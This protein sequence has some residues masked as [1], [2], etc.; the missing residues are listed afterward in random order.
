MKK[1][2]EFFFFFKKRGLT[3]RKASN[4]GVKK[5]TFFPALR[6]STVN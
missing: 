2:E 1:N 3:W 4:S 6:F 5:Y